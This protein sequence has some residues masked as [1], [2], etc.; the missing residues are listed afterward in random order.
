MIATSR[1][2]H[3]INP[4]LR[5]LCIWWRA[6]RT[7]W[8]IAST[9]SLMV[10]QLVIL[11]I[12]D[13]S[14]RFESVCSSIDCW[15]PLHRASILIQRIAP[16]HPN[17]KS[18]A[19]EIPNRFNYNFKKLFEIVYYL[20]HDEESD[21]KRTRERH[22]RWLGK[23]RQVFFNTTLGEWLE[24][25]IPDVLLYSFFN[26]ARC[27]FRKATDFPLTSHTLRFFSIADGQVLKKLRLLNVLQTCFI[28][29]DRNRWIQIKIGKEIVKN[30]SRKSCGNQLI[31]FLTSLTVFFLFPFHNSQKLD[32]KSNKM[33][34]RNFQTSKFVTAENELR[35]VR[36]VRFEIRGGK[37]QILCEWR[38]EK[39]WNNGERKKTTLKSGK[40]GHS[41]AM[42]TGFFKTRRFS[43]YKYPAKKK[44]HLS[45]ISQVSNKNSLSLDL[46]SVFTFK[47]IFSSI[48][49]CLIRFL[50]SK[51]HFLFQTLQHFIL[52]FRVKQQKNIK[53]HKHFRQ[54][55]RIGWG[56]NQ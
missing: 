1:L 35:S 29:F 55:L 10:Y 49:L 2:K 32:Q 42:S 43:T 47:T 19:N 25:L 8:R 40:K 16:P 17:R 23:D 20:V 22:L 30:S 9:I 50:Q 52:S 41:R 34:F 36:R 5:W 26:S 53:K 11:M 51:I 31:S 6:R 54:F 45:L 38:S 28:S 56:S 21:G 3:S 15:R 4:N 27:F 12:V 14:E 18:T 24:E 33:E 39:H 48:F 46:Y 44:C 13:S 37:T 7:D